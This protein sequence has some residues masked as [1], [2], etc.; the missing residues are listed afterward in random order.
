K[1]QVFKNLGVARVPATADVKRPAPFT[2]ALGQAGLLYDVILN[3]VTRAVI[4][5]RVNAVSA[6]IAEERK[7]AGQEVLVVF[8]RGDEGRGRDGRRYLL[9]PPEDRF[10]KPDQCGFAPEGLPKSVEIV[11]LQA[12]SDSQTGAVTNP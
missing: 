1:G 8:Y 6:K 9:P 3:Q 4:R 5:D 2:T 10:G 7:G 11:L 12:P